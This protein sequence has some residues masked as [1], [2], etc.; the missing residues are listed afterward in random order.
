M[1]RRQKQKEGDRSPICRLA[2]RLTDMCPRDKVLAYDKS[3]HDR[4]T[5]F[6]NRCIVRTTV[7]R[8]ARQLHTAHDKLRAGY[9]NCTLRMTNCTLRKTTV[10]CAR[11]LYAVHDNSAPRMNTGQPNMENRTATWGIFSSRTKSVLSSIECRP[12]SHICPI[13]C[14]SSRS[15]ADADVSRRIINE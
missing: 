7:P 2:A 4:K 3:T 15:D 13:S 10:R 14:L 5:Q 8:C 11:Q 12:G 1:S 9:D 6:M